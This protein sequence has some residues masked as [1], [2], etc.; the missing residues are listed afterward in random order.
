[1]RAHAIVMAPP[2]FNEDLCL[3]ERRE[4]LN[5]QEL[6]SELRVQALAVAILPRTARLD[7]ERLDADAAEPAAHVLGDEL[8]SVIRSNVFRRTM[9]D[10]EVGEAV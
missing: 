3:S 5:V 6:V 9:H 7:V 1:M 4:D 2:G 8:R 10:E